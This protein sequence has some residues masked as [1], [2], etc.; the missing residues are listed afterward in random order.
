MDTPPGLLV[1]NG[2]ELAWTLV[3]TNPGQAPL[4]ELRTEGLAA[5]CPRNELAPGEVMVC[6]AASQALGG[7]QE[8]PVT[9][10]ARSACSSTSAS[11]VGHYEGELVDVYSMPAIGIVTLVNGDDANLPPGPAIPAGTP[12]LGPTWSPTPATPSSTASRSPAS[13]ARP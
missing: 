9:A 2:S 11:A 10:T 12:V 1:E 7:R 3:I 5:A 6:T 4:S 13:R 8:V